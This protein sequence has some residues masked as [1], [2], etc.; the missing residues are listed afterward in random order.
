MVGHVLHKH[1]L[2]TPDPNLLLGD[3]HRAM[4]AGLVV[5]PG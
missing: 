2:R 3:L 5:G 1:Q 4:V